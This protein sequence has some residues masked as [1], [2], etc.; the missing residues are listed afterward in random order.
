MEY[1][2]S[3]DVVIPSTIDVL[4]GDLAK[5]PCGW[6][7]SVAPL[8][9]LVLE[10]TSLFLI[11]VLVEMPVRLLERLDI[12]FGFARLQFYSKCVVSATLQCG[13]TVYSPALRR[14]I[15]DD[16]QALYEVAARLCLP[17]VIFA[18]S[19]VAARA[20]DIPCSSERAITVDF[21]S[22]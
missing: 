5:L 20:S 18:P 16:C 21:H 17:S 1:T 7:L 6:L 13:L 4:K 8:L 14:R 9:K 3:I 11:N 22:S 12:P 10:T 19:S 15:S 2:H